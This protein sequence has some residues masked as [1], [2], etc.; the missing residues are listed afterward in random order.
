[1]AWSLFTR[2]NSVALQNRV[3]TSEL[4]I[5]NKPGQC[6]LPHLPWQ[7]VRLAVSDLG[8]RYQSNSSQE[9]V[10]K[11]MSFPTPS[12]SCFTHIG[13][14]REITVASY[15][16]SVSYSQVFYFRIIISQLFL[17][18]AES[19]RPFFSDCSAASVTHCASA[20]KTLV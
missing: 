6:H 10:L 12:F 1:M 3:V 4:S 20:V 14:A 16:G 13:V 2:V 8:Q 11:P 18:L 9:T 17:V 5:R 19:R 7:F 15:S